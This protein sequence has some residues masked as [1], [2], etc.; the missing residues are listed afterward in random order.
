MNTVF[1]IHY[2]VLSISIHYIAMI[3]PYNLV[4]HDV[5]HYF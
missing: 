1:I 4:L 5:I 2:I 3:Y